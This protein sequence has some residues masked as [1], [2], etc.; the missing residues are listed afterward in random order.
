MARQ[1]LTVQNI[2]ITGVDPAFTAAHVDGHK[3]LCDEDVCVIVKNASG[4]PVTVTVQTAVTV[5]GRAVADDTVSV[6]AT[7][8]QRFIAKFKR[9]VHGQPES[10]GADAGQ[11]FIDTSAQASVTIA[12]IKV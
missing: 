6:P 5:G 1:V 3:F 9:D 11:V 8:G 2:P 12:A 10:V 4:A 7:T